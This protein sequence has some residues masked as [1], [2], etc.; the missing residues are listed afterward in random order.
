VEFDGVLADTQAD[1]DLLVRLQEK[2]SDNTIL[3][4][5]L[6]H[7]YNAL[8]SQHLIARGVDP[9]QFDLTDQWESLQAF[10]PNLQ[11]ADLYHRFQALVPQ[12][13]ARPGADQADLA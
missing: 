3:N 2:I 13:R 11:L 7:I 5:L 8:L 4:I 10:D 12:L 9:S 6:M 1:S